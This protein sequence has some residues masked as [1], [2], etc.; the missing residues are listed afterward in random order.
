MAG[1]VYIA[2]QDTLESVKAT[3]E[4]TKATA[5][6][7]NQKAGNLEERLGTSSSVG[8][9]TVFGKLKTID[10]KLDE[11]G[12]GT[13]NHGVQR[14]TDNGTF[15]VP[16]GVTK[17]L[18]TACA[19][20][21]GGK[22][23]TSSSYGGEGGEWIFKEPYNVVPGQSLTITVGKGGAGVTTSSGSQNPGGNTVVGNLVTLLGGGV[24]GNTNG[25]AKG[26]KVD[27]DTGNGCDGFSPGGR[28]TTGKS[29][30][31][32]Y[33]YPGG[34]GSLGKGADALDSGAKAAGYGGGG[35]ASNTS[36]CIKGGD[37]IVIIEW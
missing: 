12:P 32:T 7:T 29:G 37:G 34:G 1:E 33:Y 30:S 8:S 27:N 19:G 23:Y 28:R 26:A 17:I 31:T 35:G 22:R 14:F 9:G 24:S 3:A 11:M 4:S 15:T 36:A 5:E 20:G 13:E 18:V 21:E 10:E 6:S 16:E 2:R 25:G